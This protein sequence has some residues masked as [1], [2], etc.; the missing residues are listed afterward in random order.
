MAVRLSAIDSVPFKP[1]PARPLPG[2]LG[3]GVPE[4]VSRPYHY[5]FGADPDNPLQ[6]DLTEPKLFLE[7]L[8]KLDIRLVNITAGSPYYNRIIRPALYPPSYG[9]YP[10]EE[11]FIGVTRQLCVVRD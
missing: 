7:I 9:Y 1:D 2:A 10:P 8:R 11:P 6:Y 3:P 5:A 4:D